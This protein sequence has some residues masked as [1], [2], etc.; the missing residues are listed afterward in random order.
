MAIEPHWVWL[1]LGV[2]LAAAEMLA[3][4]VYLLWLG[5]AAIV[6]GLMTWAL[7]L[8]VPVQVL[9]FVALSLIAAFSARRWLAETPIASTDPLMNRRGARMVGHTALVV[10]P[11]ADGSG[12]VKYGDSEWI[13]RG[14]P[15][16]AGQRVRIVG[17]DGSAL[18][19][20]PLPEPLESPG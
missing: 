11:I 5:L 3:P 7:G 10:Q 8:S 15:I 16:P 14:P 9:D 19:V 13:A 6:T 17:T 18:L 2:I 12:R 20:E 1:T 4:G